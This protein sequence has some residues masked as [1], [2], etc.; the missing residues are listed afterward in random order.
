MRT[1]TAGLGVLTALL[2]TALATPPGQVL[3]GP[4]PT[5]PGPTLAVIR[6]GPSAPAQEPIKAVPPLPAVT[7]G[8]AW[9]ESAPSDSSPSTE[10]SQQE[11]E[12]IARI[13]NILLNLSG[14][15]LPQ[16]HSPDGSQEEEP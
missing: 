15:P 2:A 3:F 8:V 4:R 13:A 16:A 9:S 5:F 1:L 10:A 11:L 12:Q 14:P 6:D 7:P